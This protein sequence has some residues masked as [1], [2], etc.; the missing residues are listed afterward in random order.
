MK[1]SS[2]EGGKTLSTGGG[3]RSDFR[4]VEVGEAAT[5]IDGFERLR[6]ATCKSIPDQ[7]RARNVTS[8]APGII[9]GPA[10]RA[11]RGSE[12]RATVWMHSHE[13]LSREAKAHTAPENVKFNLT[14]PQAAT[15]PSSTNSSFCCASLVTSTAVLSDRRTRLWAAVPGP[16]GGVF[17]RA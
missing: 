17:P 1:L 5:E 8:R 11:E 14:L 13:N 3:I 12:A 10:S 4:A 9:G 2:P 6:L 15:P 7:S 16:E